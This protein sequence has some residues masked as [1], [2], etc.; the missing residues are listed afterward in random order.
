VAFPRRTSRHRSI[1]ECSGPGDPGP[2]RGSGAPR[3]HRG[4]GDKTGFEAVISDDS[5]IRFLK[6]RL[7]LDLSDFSEYLGGLALVVPDPVLRRV[8]HLL[9]PAKDVGGAERL[10]YTRAVSADKR[11]ASGRQMDMLL[12]G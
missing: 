2:F 1:L 9:L 3:V 10:V 7:H 6:R 8:Q 11:L 4:F 12:A 5:A